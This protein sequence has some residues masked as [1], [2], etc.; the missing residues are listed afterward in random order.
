M[1][2]VCLRLHANA[3]LQPLNGVTRGYK[4]L[5]PLNDVEKE[6]WLRTDL[7]VFLLEVGMHV[8]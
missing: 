5:Q 8:C 4:E 3:E 6:Q 1:L 7:P 2:Q